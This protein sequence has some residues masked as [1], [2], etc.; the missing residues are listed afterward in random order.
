FSAKLGW[1][2]DPNGLVYAE[3]RYHMF[4]QHNPADSNWGNMTWGHAVSTD[5]VHWKELYAALQPDSL[6][7]MFSG[8]AIVDTRNVTG[9]KEG[10]H[11]PILLYYTAAGGNSAIS[12]GK[13]FTQCMAYSL[14][15]G[16]TFQ[17]YAGNP[18]IGHIESGNR[19]PKVVWC[20]EMG[21]YLLALYL[22]RDEYALFRS[23]D[24]LHFTELQR[25]HLV[26]DGE[27]PAFY[28][29][30][31]E[32]EENVRKWVFSGASDRYLVGNIKGSRFVPS[33]ES[34]PYFYGHRTSYA[35]QTFSGLSDRRVKIAWDVLHA[36]ES[37]F[38]NQMGIPT[39]VKLYRI[40]EDYRLSTLPVAEFSSLRV[41]SECLS[42]DSSLGLRHPLSRLP[43]EIEVK[44][45]KETADF[46]IRFFGYEL[47]VKPSE[48]TLSYHDVVMPLSYTGGDITLRL[49]SDVL[50]LEVFSD[51]GFVYSVIGS[52]ADYGIRYLTVASLTGEALPDVTVTL[53][54]LKEIW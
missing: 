31:V 7:T 11:D 5:L 28:P 54:T 48:N 34:K 13:P 30:A 24:L 46:V 45:P 26:G 21:C 18:V 36:P 4:F 23:E 47:W 20:E 29:L 16:V 35:A 40:G 44:A 42:I 2:N 53:H 50:G 1:I 19:D 12:H 32:N 51:G 10:D 43:Y 39:E 52:L 49:I 41:K 25:L 37:V 6:G 15:G 27:C 8:S 3:G 17:K 9:L 38:E 14:D 33:Q 22:D